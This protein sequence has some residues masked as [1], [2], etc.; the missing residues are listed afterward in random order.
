MNLSV[1]NMPSLQ[2]P[3]PFQLQ[4]ETKV[5][6]QTG[7]RLDLIVAIYSINGTEIANAYFHPNGEEQFVIPRIAND[8]PQ[9][10]QVSLFCYQAENRSTP[11]FEKELAFID[12][13]QDPSYLL[14]L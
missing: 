14:N 11:I 4:Q 1:Q 7:Y 12:F 6:N 13:F 5:I 10:I 2:W 8:N 9:W 3:T